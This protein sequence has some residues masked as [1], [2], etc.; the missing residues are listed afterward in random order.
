[1][2]S[3]FSVNG[4]TY[5]GANS[6]QKRHAAREGLGWELELDRENVKAYRTCIIVREVHMFSVQLTG[7]SSHSLTS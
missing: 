4:N 1:M 3:A 7:S 2:K 5:V 6:V